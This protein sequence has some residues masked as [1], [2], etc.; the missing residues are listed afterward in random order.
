MCML[1]RGLVFNRQHW[2]EKANSKQLLLWGGEIFC[3]LT[4]SCL[5]GALGI[6]WAKYYCRY[7]KET[8]MLTMIPMEQKPGAKQ[9]SFCFR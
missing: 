4:F 2:R 6:S 7:E 8:R 5:V 3:L 9:V 1:Y